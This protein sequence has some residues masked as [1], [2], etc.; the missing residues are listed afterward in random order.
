MYA[1]ENGF[2]HLQE[3]KPY[4]QSY[5]RAR[6]E[7][8][9]ILKTAKDKDYYGH[10]LAK[11]GIVERWQRE[12]NIAIGMLER[13]TGQK[14][15]DNS[16]RIPPCPVFSPEVEDKINNGY[17]SPEKI[18]EREDEKDN[19]RKLKVLAELVDDRDKVVKRAENEYVIK[20]AVVNANLPLDSFIYYNHTN[21][22]V[23]NWMDSPYREKV[24]KEQFDAFVQSVDYYKLPMGIK[25]KLGK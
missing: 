17:Y 2:Y 14:F 8:F 21:E 4:A 22:G 11:L 9:E 19:K 25:F 16:T 5:V 13:L 3:G 15:E 20:L 1:V 6:D 24:T 10:L 7:E 23:F 18:Q 12:A